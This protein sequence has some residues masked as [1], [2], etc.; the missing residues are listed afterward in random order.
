MSNG[1]GTAAGSPGGRYV[2]SK[3]EAYTGRTIPLAIRRARR[4]TCWLSRRLAMTTAS[5]TARLHLQRRF[6]V[7][8]T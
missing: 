5:P 7:T 1:K 8:G 3:A 6:S 4:S 2:L